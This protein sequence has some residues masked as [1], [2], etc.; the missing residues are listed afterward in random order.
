VDL[1]AVGESSV[2]GSS[3]QTGPSTRSILGRRFPMPFQRTGA[4]EYQAV[5]TLRRAMQNTLVD[6]WWIVVQ[7]F[8][9]QMIGT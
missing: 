5:G 3:I 8:M 4:A 2:D 7:S 6:Q 9:L 1:N